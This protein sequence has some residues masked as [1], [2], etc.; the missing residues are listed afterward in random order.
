M[1]LIKLLTSPS[2]KCHRHGFFR[3]CEFC[4]FPQVRFLFT[5]PRLYKTRFWS[6]PR[7]FETHWAEAQVICSNFSIREAM[8]SNCVTC[9]SPMIVLWILSMVS[10][11][12]IVSGL[13]RQGSSS[14]LPLPL[15]NSA[16]HCSPCYKMG[17]L[18]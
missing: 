3:G 14:R 5:L 17:N 4:M 2:S 11:G 7:R 9:Q 12:M 18:S 8:Y 6:G 10:C 13:S 15:L 1:H 16:T